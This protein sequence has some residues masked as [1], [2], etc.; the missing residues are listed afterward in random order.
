MSDVKLQKR[1]SVRNII[2]KVG[3]ILDIRFSKIED[4]NPDSIGWETKSGQSLITILF[5]YNSEKSQIFENDYKV[6][7]CSLNPNEIADKVR[8]IIVA[9]LSN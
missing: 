9:Q 1:N 4:P 7:N 3:K 5:D 6:C 8:A 2:R